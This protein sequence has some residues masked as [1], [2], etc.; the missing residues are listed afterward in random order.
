LYRFL[1]RRTDSKFNKLVLKRLMNSR[2][3][4]A[5]ISLSRLNRFATKKSFK[6]LETKGAEP[7]F[8]IVATVTDDVRLLEIPKL[9]VCA[10]KFSEKARARITA[11]GGFCTTFDQLAINRPSGEHVVLLRGPRD[12]ET[13]KHFG[14]A[15]GVPGSS[16]K[17]IVR[18]KG[19]KFEKARG[20]RKSR[21]YKA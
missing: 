2:V 20:K 8:A 17:P 5:P 7:I 19:R 9:R 21:G 10:L 12:R 14:R 18:A 3:H 1:A 6:D 16:A 15:P 4:R 11:A 13:L